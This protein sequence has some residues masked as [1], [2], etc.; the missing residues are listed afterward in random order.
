MR[1]AAKAVGIF[2]IFFGICAISA[3]AQEETTRP[4]NQP[5]T[6]PSVFGSPELTADG[7]VTLTS[8]TYAVFHTS[9]GDF[10]A[11][12]D[13]ELAPQTVQNFT[14]Y[15]TGQ[16]S[17]RHPVTM[18][19]TTRPLYSN[20]T[21]Y[22]VVPNSMIFGGD[23]LNRGEGDSGTQ[24]PLETSRD[25]Q[26]DQ[27]GLLA[28]DSS[29]NRMSG[30]R[31]FITLRPFPER[32]GNYTIFG[33]V[34]GGLDLVQRISMKPVRRPQLPLDPVMVYFIEIVRVPAGRMTTGEFRMENGMKVLRIEPNFQDAPLALM[35]APAP[36]VQDEI[37]T[38]TEDETTETEVL[39]ENGAA[40]GDEADNFN[41]R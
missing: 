29:G 18:D 7:N 17:W 5:G 23:P 36:A 27:P 39:E 12:L 30:S 26:F 3:H 25:V 14:A 2:T 37:T 28:M 11:A 19:E 20:T 41:N 34:I 31:W 22:R 16:K 10:I 21:I 6:L 9:E 8:G 15:A 4:V 32:T 35:E 1:K 13:A 38:I 24:L 33:R 40:E